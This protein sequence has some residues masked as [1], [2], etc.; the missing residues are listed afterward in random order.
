MRTRCRGVRHVLRLALEL[1]SPNFELAHL[2]RTPQC[3]QNANN[4]SV[5][6]QDMNRTYFEPFRAPKNGLLG[7]LG[8][9][10]FFW[11]LSICR[12][13]ESRLGL[14]LVGFIPSYPEVSLA[15]RNISTQFDLESA[16]LLGVFT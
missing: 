11:D 10:V 6:A 9:A 8:P 7:P 1:W 16:R 3:S 15:E 14:H 13:H 2:N 5:G 12:V 4:A